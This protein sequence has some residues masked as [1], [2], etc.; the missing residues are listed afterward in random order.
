MLRRWSKHCKWYCSLRSSG[1]DIEQRAGAIDQPSSGI[2]GVIST[3][4]FWQPDSIQAAKTFLNFR[5]AKGE[6]RGYTR[7][8]QILRSLRRILRRIFV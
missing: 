5:K 4:F 2:I 1:P 3:R 6:A 7:I 8:L